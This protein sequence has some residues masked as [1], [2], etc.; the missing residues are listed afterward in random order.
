[1]IIVVM[2]I[3]EMTD[4]MSGDDDDDVILAMMTMIA[5]AAVVVMRCAVG[6]TRAQNLNHCHHC[7]RTVLEVGK[8]EKISSL[9]M[10]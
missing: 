10:V 9:M 6:R 2:M 1:M 4:L 3:L 5:A 8:Y 7:W